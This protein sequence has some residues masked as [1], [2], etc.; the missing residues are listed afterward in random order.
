MVQVT[1]ESKAAD[2]DNNEETNPSV[3][4]PGHP[5]IVVKDT[6]KHSIFMH[7]EVI[8]AVLEFSPDKFLVHVYPTKLLV[9]HD[10]EVVRAIIDPAPGNITKNW[11]C[12]LP[13]FDEDDFP[14]VV[15]SGYETCNIV[16]V[17]TGTIQ[18]FLHAPAWYCQS[19]EGGF[20]IHRQDTGN[21]EFH[22]ANKQI[23]NKNEPFERYFRYVLKRD[24]VEA[25]KKCGRLPHAVTANYL[26]EIEDTER[27]KKEVEELGKAN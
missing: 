13:T 17:K 23:S 16:N 24:I 5:Q 20:F 21:I 12:P 11:L 2:A 8:K 18:A 3:E 25:L 6:R 22:M 19:M 4:E 27:L 15:C 1:E 26:N 7:Y 10:W 14:Y 9:M